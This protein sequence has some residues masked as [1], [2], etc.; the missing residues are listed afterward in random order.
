MMDEAKTSPVIFDEERPFGD[1]LRP[2][3]MYRGLT[4][5]SMAY[6][7]DGKGFLDPT[8]LALRQLDTKNVGYLDNGKVYE[9]MRALQDEQKRSSELIESVR[10]AHNKAM[11]FKKMVIALSMFAALLAVSNVGTSFAAAR[12][13][14]DTEVNALNDLV[15]MEGERIATTPKIVE[16]EMTAA[17]D[18]R[19]QRHLQVAQTAVCGS[20]NSSEISCEFQGEVN[21]SEVTAMHKQFCPNYPTDGATSCISGGVDQVL[22]RCNDVDTLIS[23]VRTIPTVSDDFVIFPERGRSYGGMQEIPQFGF[24]LSMGGFPCSQ[25]FAIGFYCPPDDSETCYA[26]ANFQRVCLGLLEICGPPPAETTST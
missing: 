4:P 17:K 19:R 18:A 25:P 26:F 1:L 16:V 9:I 8:E 23:A 6:D 12:L 15:N 3:A 21:L 11:G 10:R 13:A 7:R 14:R 2:E 20:F 5:C 24:G 22:L